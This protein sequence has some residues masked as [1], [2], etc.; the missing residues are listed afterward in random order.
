MAAAHDTPSVVAR[1]SISI[2][3][4]VCRPG[5]GLSLWSQTS[6]PLAEQIHG[7]EL[8]RIRTVP[9]ESSA[10]AMLLG[11]RFPIGLF[12]RCWFVWIRLELRRIRCPTS[13]YYIDHAYQ[14]NLVHH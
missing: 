3:M 4:S 6:R 1:T 5:A 7:W 14:A 12:G 2:C 11:G 10:G 8:S 9:R 13:S